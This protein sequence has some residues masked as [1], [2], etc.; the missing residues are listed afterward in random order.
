MAYGIK[1]ETLHYAVPPAD[2]PFL[3]LPKRIQPLSQPGLLHP[4]LSIIT[5]FQDQGDK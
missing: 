3:P 2:S 5:Y 4:A 1:F